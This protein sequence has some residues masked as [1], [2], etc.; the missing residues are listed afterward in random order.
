MWYIFC[1]NSSV[2]CLLRWYW[3]T[4]LHCHGITERPHMF[5]ETEIRE[6][7]LSTAAVLLHSFASD[8]RTCSMPHVTRPPSLLLVDSR[9]YYLYRIALAS[10]PVFSHDLIW[11]KLCR[12]KR[13]V[14]CRISP[15]HHQCYYHLF[16]IPFFQFA[17]PFFYPISLSSFWVYISHIVPMRKY[18]LF[19]K[20]RQCKLTAVRVFANR[21]CWTD[22]FR[23]QPLSAK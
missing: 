12:R 5:S 3:R 9:S 18:E 15:Y 4:S 2:N 22:D 10:L 17:F 21:I 11:F 8:D 6:F 20:P 19:V 16:L 14:P 1:L 13:K 7:P 23:D